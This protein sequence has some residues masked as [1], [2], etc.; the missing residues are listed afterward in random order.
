[1]NEI[2][3]ISDPYPFFRGMIAEVGYKVALIDYVQPARIKGFS[4]LELFGGI[5][6]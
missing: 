4:R 2:R 6:A 1:M 3:R 5:P